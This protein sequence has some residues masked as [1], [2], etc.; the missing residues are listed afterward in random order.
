MS[1]ATDAPRQGDGPVVGARR[2]VFTSPCLAMRE[3]QGGAMLLYPPCDGRQTF[4]LESENGA[5][6]ADEE[7]APFFSV[8]HRVSAATAPLIEAGPHVRQSGTLGLCSFD[9]IERL[10]GSRRARMCRDAAKEGL[11]DT[12]LG[13]HDRRPR[14]HSLIPANGVLEPQMSAAVLTQ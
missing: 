10:V 2:A 6:A 9:L 14:L 4:G 7:S 13:R 8:A 1:T 12:L 5:D 11:L 3:R